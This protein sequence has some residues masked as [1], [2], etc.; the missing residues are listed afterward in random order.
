[1]SNRCLLS[2]LLGFPCLSFRIFHNKLF[3]MKNL[4][5]S[6]FYVLQHSNFFTLRFLFLSFSWEVHLSQIWPKSALL[7]LFT[8]AMFVQ[9]KRFGLLLFIYGLHLLRILWKKLVREA[10]EKKFVGWGRQFSSS[11]ETDESAKA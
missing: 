2:M 6:I 3:L 8:G 1:M 10:C 7:T 9:L 5:A 11:S 4:D